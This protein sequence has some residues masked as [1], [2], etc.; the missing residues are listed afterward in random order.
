MARETDCGN[1]H[2][3]EM[4]RRALNAEVAAWH[5]KGWAM[6]VDGLIELRSVSMYPR[7][8]EDGVGMVMAEAFRRLAETLEPAADAPPA[9]PAPPPSATIPNTP[10]ELL[11]EPEGRA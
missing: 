8:A 3:A 2:H 1:V 9:P 11:G 6:L 7:E 10:R 5:L 4:A